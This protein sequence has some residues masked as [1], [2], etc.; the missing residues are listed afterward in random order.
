MT[1]TQEQI[2][3]AKTLLANTE[4]LRFFRGQMY[5]GEADEYLRQL[6]AF[7]TDYL[8]PA[9]G[10]DMFN[11]MKNKDARIAELEKSLSFYR[12]NGTMGVADLQARI[13]ELEA[14]NERL[15]D[16]LREPCNDAEFGMKP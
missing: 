1:P 11:E 5:D 12:E 14:E 7:L 8:A 13:A 10:M 16:Q 3:A 6:H 2:E 9:A 15:K 4:K